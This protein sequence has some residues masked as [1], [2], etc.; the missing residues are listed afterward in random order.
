MPSRPYREL[1]VHI[2]RSR[3]KGI[4]PEYIATRLQPPNA[5]YIFPS[6]QGLWECAVLISGDEEAYTGRDRVLLAAR[7]APGPAGRTHGKVSS[8]PSTERNVRTMQSRSRKDIELMDPPPSWH[9]SA[10]MLEYHVKYAH[11]FV[12]V[13]NMSSLETLQLVKEM[14][15]AVINAAAALGLVGDG[16]GRG[17]LPIVLVGNVDENLR[18]REDDPRAQDQ[19]QATAASVGAE[20][21]MLAERWGCQLFEV[22]TGSGD[23]LSESA[24]EAFLAVL[25]RI[26]EARRPREPGVVYGFS[27]M[28]APQRLLFRRTVGRVLPGALLKLFAK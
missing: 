4:D 20:A 25:R 8:V 17:S 19:N 27:G 10:P 7:R 9:R 26:E 2:L 6:N 3:D 28:R 1:I 12:F 16:G 11:G 22:D 14:F 24:S 15:E 5:H 18:R 21:A 13:F 23:A